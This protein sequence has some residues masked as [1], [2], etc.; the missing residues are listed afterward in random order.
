MSKVLELCALVGAH[1]SQAVLTE[2]DMSLYPSSKC[3]LE[4]LPLQATLLSEG[5][6][7]LPP[8]NSR[9]EG[10]KEHWRR[11]EEEGTEGTSPAFPQG[12]RL[13]LRNLFIFPKGSFPT[14]SHGA[15]ADDPCVW[16]ADRCHRP[17][18]S[19]GA[20]NGRT[21]VC[22]AKSQSLSEADGGQAQADAPEI[23]KLKA[24]ISGDP[25]TDACLAPEMPGYSQDTGEASLRV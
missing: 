2:A 14:S 9:R 21:E 15:S 5:C 3:Y 22:M 23:S 17:G 25:T 10:G 1:S 6:Y 8:Y 11:E 12:L 13:C 24:A 19:Q 7:F 4:K 20:F 18:S 16:T